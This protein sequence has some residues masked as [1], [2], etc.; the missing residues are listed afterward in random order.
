MEFLQ[1]TGWR[2]ALEAKA[3]YPEAVPIF[4]GTDL[5]VELNFARGRPEA[6]LDLTCVPEIREWGEDGGRIQAG[7][8]RGVHR[9]SQAERSGA[10]RA[11]RRLPRTGGRGSAAVLQD[12][13]PQRDGDSGVFLRSSPAPGEEKSRDL[14]RVGGADPRPGR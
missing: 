9:R 14:P 10:E 3:A 7:A 5:M 2:E 6:V 11:H 4:G 8:R 12:R 13:H 1:P